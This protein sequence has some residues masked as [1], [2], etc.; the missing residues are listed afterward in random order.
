MR[1]FSK[2]Y[3]KLLKILVFWAKLVFFLTG[4]WPRK[5]GAKFGI[6]K[7]PTWPKKQNFQQFLQFF[8]ENSF[9]LK[10]NFHNFWAKFRIPHFF[11]LE[12]AAIF[13]GILNLKNEK[14]I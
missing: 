3:S 12:L 1:E 7:K 9:M 2:K 13:T 5:T 11:E 6:E 10:K 8:F 14:K 4:T